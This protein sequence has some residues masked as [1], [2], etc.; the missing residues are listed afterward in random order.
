MELTSDQSALIEEACLN[1][2]GSFSAFIA[3]ADGID[4]CSDWVE[5]AAQELGEPVTSVCRT[6]SDVP[7]PEVEECRAFS[8]RT[9]ECI[10]ERSPAFE[11]ISAGGAKFIDYICRDQVAKDEIPRS[12]FGVVMSDTPCDQF[13][14]DAYV[15]FFIE[16]ND[17]PGS[18][19]LETLC[20]EGPIYSPEGCADACGLLS[21]CIPPGSEGEGLRDPDSCMY[22]CVS[23]EEVPAETWSCVEDATTCIGAGA[24]FQQ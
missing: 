24:C 6:D 8:T 5:F 10:V 19:S 2:C 18:G 14:I 22:F 1:R 11:S 7:P 4:Q 3:I 17:T 12:T 20:S 9:A 23:S 21:P 15:S 16:V 13:L